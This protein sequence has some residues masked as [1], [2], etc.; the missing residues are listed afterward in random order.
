MLRVQRDGNI[1]RIKELDKSLVKEISVDPLM[2]YS[3]VMSGLFHER[4]II[5]EADADCMFYS[6]LLDIPGVH[7]SH[8]PDVLFVHASGKNRMAALAKSLR[9]LDVPVDVI[10]DIDILREETDLR[11]VVEALGGDWSQTQSVAKSV[12]NAIEQHKPWLNSNEIRQAIE[13]VLEQ[14]PLAGNSRKTYALKLR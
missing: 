9:A 12:K 10:A 1:N 13:T 6:S 14:T 2:K 8:Q 4:V 3:S 11:R 7:K 5:C